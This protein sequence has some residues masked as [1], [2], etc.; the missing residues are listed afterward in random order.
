MNDLADHELRE[1]TG[2][3]LQRATAATM[4]RVNRVLKGFGLRRTTYSALTVVKDVP[5]LNQSQLAKALSIERPNM[6]QVI[7]ELEKLNLLERRAAPNDRRTYALRATKAGVDLQKRAY[8]DLCR[9]EG[10]LTKG[11]SSVQIDQLHSLLSILEANAT[12]SSSRKE[13]CS[14][15][16]KIS[17]A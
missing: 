9:L 16:H 8:Q 6:V 10:E 12:S 11:M 13:A 5:N 2:Y 3:R 7:D 17:P 15:E 14:D 1:L 4:P